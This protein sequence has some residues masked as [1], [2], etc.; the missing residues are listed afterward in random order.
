[1][2]RRNRLNCINRVTRKQ[3]LQ[4]FFTYHIITGPRLYKILQE[5]F[6]ITAIFKKTT[7]LGNLI[8]KRGRQ[9]EKQFTAN[10]V[11]KVPCKECNKFYIG[12]SKNSIAKRV[13]QHKAVCRRNVK[14]SKLKSSKKDNGIAFHHIKTGHDFDF[15]KT[16]IIARDTNYWRRLILEGIAIKSQEMRIL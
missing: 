5:Q 1:M 4:M 10:T 9:K 2:M 3:I 12:Q 8:K 6:G 14:L 11:Y 16:A 15:D 7:T 13:S